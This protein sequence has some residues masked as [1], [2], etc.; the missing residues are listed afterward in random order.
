V[1]PFPNAQ[2]VFDGPCLRGPFTNQIALGL[3]DRVSNLG[4]N[5]LTL[6]FSRS[7]GA[8]GGK[9][10]E[11]ATGLVRPF[12]GVVLQNAGVG[13]GFLECDGQTA[14]VELTR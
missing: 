10:T 6:S 8:F 9:V 2:V 1:L 12:R 7:S 11:P 14:R 13:L 3:S 4:S 5:R